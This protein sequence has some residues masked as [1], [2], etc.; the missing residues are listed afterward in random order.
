MRPLWFCNPLF[1]GVGGCRDC[2]SRRSCVVLA[3][4]LRFIV[5]C[6]A[7]AA[8]PVH[9]LSFSQIQSECNC[10]AQRTSIILVFP[11]NTPRVRRCPGPHVAVVRPQPTACTLLCMFVEFVFGYR[12]CPSLKSALWC[13]G[14]SC[15]TRRT[16]LAST[17][18]C[19]S[20]SA[21]QVGV[22]AVPVLPSR[23]TWLTMA[24]ET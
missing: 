11:S 6:P 24:K 14:S 8:V 10:G 12:C 15:R 16:S 13:R 4:R 5:Y 17:A 23:P 21:R 22:G 1:L 3:D 18:K 20:G 19:A 7:L 9:W 2:L